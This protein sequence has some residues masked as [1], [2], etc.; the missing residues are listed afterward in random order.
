MVLF[1]ILLCHMAVFCNLLCCGVFV[2]E[3]T[4]GSFVFLNGGEAAYMR[5]EAVIGVIVVALA[6]FTQQ[7]RT[8]TFFDGEIVVE[9]LLNMNTFTGG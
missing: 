7:H 4:V 2:A 3:Q 8:C 5:I 9:I 6:D 1:V